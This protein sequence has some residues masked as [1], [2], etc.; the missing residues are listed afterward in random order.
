MNLISFEYFAF[1]FFVILI[2]LF[3][4]RKISLLFLSSIIFYFFSGVFGFFVILV[5]V[6]FNYLLGLSVS[7]EKYRRNVFALVSIFLNVF[8]L[9]LF[10]I[11]GNIY[12]INN[13]E[14]Y[15]PFGLSFIIFTLLSY[16]IE[17][18][19]GNILPEKNFVS[20]TAYILY[21]PKIMQGPIERPKTFF[22]EITKSQEFDYSGFVYGLKLIIWGIFKKTVIADRAA[23]ITNNIFNGPNNYSGIATIIGVLLY[24]V[25]IYADFSGYID[26]AIGSSN[27]LGVKLTRNFN[28]PYF[29][30]SIKE[31][32]DKW[33]ITL[34]HWLR[35]Y[36]FLPISYRLIKRISILNVKRST[37]EIIVYSIS[38][39]VTFFI[40]GLWHGLSLNY[41]IWGLLFA[42]YLI[43][44]RLTLKK[45]KKLLKAIKISDKNKLLNFYRV[46]FT[47]SLVS[48]TW[49]FFRASNFGDSIIILRN[50]CEGFSNL[51]KFSDLAFIKSIFS[52]FGL[53]ETEFYILI[54]S[55][56][57]LFITEYFM[58][59]GNIFDLTDNKN[60]LIR[61]ITY[62]A[63]VLIVLFL[64]YKGSN[65]DFIYLQF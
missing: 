22:N 14:F 5:I 12:F 60:Y 28:S 43:F 59:G 8:L 25:Q 27:L 24:T 48:F 30:K 41:L 20:F 65:Q 56:L 51:M 19:R 42:V 3:V 57:V 4:N 7:K 52:G 23:V 46:L 11:L 47:I 63:M 49:I 44:S 50:I 53:P 55:I 31:F 45:R 13:N 26:I 40:C 61:W 64:S 16:N 54:F 35:D 9:L 33:H 58:R 6:L 39:F 21:F 38:I 34:S 15:S 32:W 2:S 10:K 17:I 29:A 37:G 36:I 62:Y 1:L 18:F